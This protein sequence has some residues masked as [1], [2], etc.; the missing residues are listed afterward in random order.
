MQ[1]AF[2]LSVCLHSLAYMDGCLFT[3]A[4]V[5]V[6][7]RGNIVESAA[8]YSSP[9]RMPLFPGFLAIPMNVNIIN[10]MNQGASTK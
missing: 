3:S 4:S 8:P 5:G 10:S 1:T 2:R 6:N 9:R 7:E